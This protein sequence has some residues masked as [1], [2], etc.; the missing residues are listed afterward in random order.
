MG[1]RCPKCRTIFD[2]PQGLGGHLWYAHKIRS[3]SARRRRSA[4]SVEEL[5]SPDALVVEVKTERGPALKRFRLAGADPQ[6]IVR[7][8][9]D[10]LLKYLSD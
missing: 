5:L 8:V 3:K 7:V 1:A 6:S 9:R 2:S 10:A 4:G